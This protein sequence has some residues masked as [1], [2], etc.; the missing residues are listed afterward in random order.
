M[1]NRSG[2]NYTDGTHDEFGNVWKQTRSMY[3]QY[4]TRTSNIRYF[5][6]GGTTVNEAD[7]ISAE[8]KEALNRVMGWVSPYL[9][10]TTAGEQ[11][12]KAD[13]GLGKEKG[14]PAHRGREGGQEEGNPRDSS[15]C[16][17]TERGKGKGTL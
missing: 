1:L 3:S 15:T 16:E 6:G 17:E 9:D 5:G 7:N 11:Y 14:C 4:D 2:L 8:Q 12:P 13:S 10:S